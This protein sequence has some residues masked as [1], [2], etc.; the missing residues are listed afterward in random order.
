M[1]RKEDETY[2]LSSVYNIL[3]EWESFR[4]GAP[5]NGM[6][7]GRRMRNLRSCEMVERLTQGDAA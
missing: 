4:A 7:S 3:S 6:M 1:A 2:L 5:N